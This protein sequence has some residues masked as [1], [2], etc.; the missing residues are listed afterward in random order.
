MKRLINYLRY[1][2]YWEAYT[3]ELPLIA[4]R[5]QKLKVISVA[6]EE[7]FSSLE[8]ITSQHVQIF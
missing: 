3:T 5:L 6:G 4:E 2:D 7:S 8:E 1:L